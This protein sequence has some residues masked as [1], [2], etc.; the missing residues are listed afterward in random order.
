M[1]GIGAISSKNV[2][3]TLAMREFLDMCYMS[4]VAHRGRHS[5]G[6]AW[7]NDEGKLARIR[8]LGPPGEA[9]YVASAASPPIKAILG[10]VRI[11]SQGSISIKN[12]HPFF[13]EDETLALIHNGHL[14]NSSVKKRLD[15]HKFTSETDSEMILHMFEEKMK[16]REITPENYSNAI[17][18]TA[19]EFAGAKNF[20]ILTLDGTILAYADSALCMQKQ[21]DSIRIASVPTTRSK[22]WVRLDAGTALVIHDGDLQCKSFR[23]Q[24]A[25]KYYSALS[26][27]YDEDAPIEVHKANLKIETPK[28]HSMTAQEF[29]DS[30]KKKDEGTKIRKY[31]WRFV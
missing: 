18:D 15:A 14:V 6:I 9:A 13:N 17:L 12:A 10:H 29:L 27:D 3:S 1:C 28:I 16:G 31:N 26:E 23:I 22:N 24:T 30:R 5:N 20:I 11:A 21:E 8:E 2:T 4:F 7:I 19:D 25:G